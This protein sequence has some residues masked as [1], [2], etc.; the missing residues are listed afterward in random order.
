MEAWFPRK[1]AYREVASCSNA[2]DFQARR[3]GIRV[4]KA[5]G[6]KRLAHTLNS[7]AVATSRAL[8]AILENGQNADG[9][10]TVPRV[11]REFVGKDV[12]GRAS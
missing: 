7:T 10:V 12:I 11:L 2:V 9:T 3:L 4:G 8:V 1:N 6:E 5:G